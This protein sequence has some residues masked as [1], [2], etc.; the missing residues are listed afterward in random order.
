VRNEVFYRMGFDDSEIVALLTGGHVYGRC[1]PTASGYAG[2]WV[3]HPTQF[4]N[5]YATD[6]LGDEWRLVGH[7]DTW[8]DAQG[9]GELRPAPGKRQYVNQRPRGPDEEQEDAN[10]MMLLS[11]MILAW[12][13]SFRLHLQKY[14]DDEGALKADFGAAFKKLTELGCGF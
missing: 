1:H 7:G 11:D 2:A 10:Q 12:D 13:P 5:D 14:A 4:S 3:E 6:M 9:S 8:L